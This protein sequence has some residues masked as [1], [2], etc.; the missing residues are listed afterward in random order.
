[1]ICITPN[2]TVIQG[3]GRVVAHPDL[4][5]RVTL[6]MHSTMCNA[7]ERRQQ[8]VLACDDRAWR[9]DGGECPVSYRA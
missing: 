6:S 7:I 9:R 2:A 1:V 8:K 5:R 3:G 4:G